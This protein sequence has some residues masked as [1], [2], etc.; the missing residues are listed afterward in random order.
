MG[1]EPVQLT[2]A[3]LTGVALGV[4]YFGGL[5]MSVRTLPRMNRPALLML[6]SLAARMAVVLAGF[7]LVMQGRWERLIVCL[8]GFLVARAIMIRSTAVNAT[9]TD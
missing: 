5:W 9:G 3:A 7:Y 4:L 6:V 2:I 1:F 8:L